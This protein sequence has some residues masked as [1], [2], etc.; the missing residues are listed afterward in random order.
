MTTAAKAAFYSSVS[1]A[2][3]QYKKYPTKEDYV[4]VAVG[5]PYPTL[6]SLE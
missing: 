1:S 5:A 4:N 2:M 3:F 6:Q